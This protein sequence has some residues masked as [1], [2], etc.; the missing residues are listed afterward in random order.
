[1]KAGILQPLLSD[2]SN[3]LPHFQASF[4]AYSKLN[5]PAW[6]SNRETE[7]QRDTNEVVDQNALGT[8]NTGWKKENR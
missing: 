7:R 5:K 1:M 2:N 4:Y 8:K 3:P 6:L